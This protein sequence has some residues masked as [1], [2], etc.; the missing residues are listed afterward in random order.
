MRFEG[1]RLWRTE[2]FYAGAVVTSIGVA[3]ATYGLVPS[4]AI[5]SPTI[6][7]LGVFLACMGLIVFD[8]EAYYFV[9]NRQVWKRLLLLQAGAERPARSLELEAKMLTAT[10]RDL[11]NSSAADLVELDKAELLPESGT[12]VVA[13]GVRGTFQGILVL[14]G[15]VAALAWSYLLL[16]TYAR[17]APSAY[18]VVVWLVSTVVVFLLPLVALIP[19]IVE[20]GKLRTIR[21]RA[22][23]GKDD[24]S[25][26]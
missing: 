26:G 5:V 20:A 7:I 4:V 13:T 17:E 6:A 11:E 23:P 22:R 14:L 21:R 9:R 16:L 10:I 18:N 12:I 24:G 8:L 25:S 1:E 3:A 19:G 15:M 2:E